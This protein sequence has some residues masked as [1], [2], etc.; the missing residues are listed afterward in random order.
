LFAAIS[1]VLSDSR[2]T[3]IENAIVALV[4]IRVVD[5]LGRASKMKAPT[6][7]M[8]QELPVPK[9]DIAI[10]VY[11]YETGFITDLHLAVWKYNRPA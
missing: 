7:A 2:R 9:V 5:D 1:V 3:K 4:H 8:S 10:A 11:V 6:E